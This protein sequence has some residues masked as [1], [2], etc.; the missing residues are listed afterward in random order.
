M[1]VDFADAK[2]A[3]YRPT[4]VLSWSPTRQH[5]I[6]EWSNWPASNRLKDI[7]GKD[8]AGD[9]DAARVRSDVSQ[10]PPCR[11]DLLSA[12]VG[13]GQSRRPVRQGPG[14]IAMLFQNLLSAPGRMSF[15]FRRARSPGMQSL[16]AIMNC[17]RRKRSEARVHRC[18]RQ[19]RKIQRDRRSR[20][21]RTAVRRV[22]C[23]RQRRAHAGRLR[24]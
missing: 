12:V 14:N 16:R 13:R 10:T 24:E 15:G 5:R 6:G 19:H 7:D 3:D 22:R 11:R 21:R 8:L 23:A 17:A 2:N 20:L 4:S 18:I 1:T 9:V